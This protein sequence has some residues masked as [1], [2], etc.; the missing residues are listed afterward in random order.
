MTTRRDLIIHQGPG[1]HGFHSSFT[2][3][4]QSE[5]QKEKNKPENSCNNN[6]SNQANTA[7]SRDTIAIE[8]G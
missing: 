1:F 6:G 4:L 2:L 8:Y 3:T 5:K 7:K